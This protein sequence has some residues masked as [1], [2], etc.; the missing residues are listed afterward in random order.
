MDIIGVVKNDGFRRKVNGFKLISGLLIDWI[1]LIFYASTIR[2]FPSD[3]QSRGQT[4]RKKILVNYMKT[5]IMECAIEEFWTFAFSFIWNGTLTAFITQLSGYFRK[6][7]DVFVD[8]KLILDS[9][10]SWHST[11]YLSDS[12]LILDDFADGR[13]PQYDSIKCSSQPLDFLTSLFLW[14]LKSFWILSMTI[15]SNKP[16]FDLL[17]SL[18][19]AFIHSLFLILLEIRL[20]G[21]N[22]VISLMRYPK[23]KAQ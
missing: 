21:C 11:A 6:Q 10:Q 19:L 5:P 18:L 20:Q 15:I 12:W 16:S 1:L 8:R 3:S 17:D 14:F 4:R 23:N 7:T 9:V 22:A 2:V 13:S